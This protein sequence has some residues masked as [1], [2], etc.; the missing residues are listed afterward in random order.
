MIFFKGRK[1]GGR[2]S[3]KGGAKSNYSKHARAK[4]RPR[5]GR[6][7]GKGACP[8]LYDSLPQHRKKTIDE[9]VKHLE[10]QVE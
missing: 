1:N 2:R 5:K 3:D 7:R 4:S 10:H 8:S 9:I 6:Q